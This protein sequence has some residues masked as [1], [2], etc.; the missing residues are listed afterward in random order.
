MYGA[1]A[2]R[3]KEIQSCGK[4]RSGHRAWSGMSSETS[5]T[6]DCYVFIKLIIPELSGPPILSIS[7]TGNWQ[8]VEDGESQVYQYTVDGISNALESATTAQ[9]T[10][11]IWVHLRGTSQY[12]GTSRMGL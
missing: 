2:V 1:D 7:P 9:S 3:K 6:K 8:M 12:L 5:S 10:L 4:Q 11:K